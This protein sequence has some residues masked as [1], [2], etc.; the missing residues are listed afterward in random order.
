[1]LYLMVHTERVFSQMYTNSFTGSSACPTNGNTPIIALNATGVALSR[2]TIT[3]SATANVFNSST[4]N[5][6]VNLAATSYIE[7]SVDRKCRLYFKS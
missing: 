3:C 6:T 7:F 1:M 2:N 4:L 5:N